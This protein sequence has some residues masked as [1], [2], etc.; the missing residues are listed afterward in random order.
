SYNHGS[1][2]AST[3]YYYKAWS[4]DG[5]I[6]YSSGV[7]ANATTLK[8]EPT[9]HVTSFTVAKDGTYGYNRIDLSWT[10]NDGAQAPDGYLIKAS[11]A[12][13][14]TDPSDG[15]A[16]DDNTT[17]GSNSGAINIAHGTTSY[18]W[19]GL[20]AEQ[21]YYFKIY[22]YTNSGTAI[23]YKTDGTV[24]SGSTTTN[25][26]PSFPNAWINEIHYDNVDAD[27]N[28]GVEVV[29][30]N[31]GNYTLSNFSVQFY[32]GSGGV[33]YAADTLGTF[34][35]GT[36]SNNFTIFYKMVPGLQNGPPD[37][38]ALCYGAHVITSQFLSYEGTITATEGP[39]LGL[40]S[41]DIGVSEGSGTTTQSLQ[42]T[43][44]GTAYSDF[45][46]QAN[47]TQTWGTKNDGGD[48]SLPVELIKFEA[49]SNNGKVILAWTTES[50]TDNLGF[51]LESRAECIE[52]GEWT[53]VADYKSAVA[54]A[55]QGSTTQRTDYQYTD[56]AV[57]P[58][59]T[60]FY[61]L[62]DVDYAGNLTWH[63]T[64]QVTVPAAEQATQAT[65]FGLHR[66]YPNPFNPAVTLSYDITSDNQTTLQ[67]FNV[68]G[69]LV[70]TLVDEY[71]P[72][73]SYSLSWQPNLLSAGV[74]LV[75]L[76]NGGQ[77]NVQKV[78]YVK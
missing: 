65:E 13:N 31:I 70:A 14:I 25:A 66:A 34:T 71:Q 27:E 9:N 53:T 1:L 67:V 22:P 15:T 37:G 10:A 54:L 61:R 42:L 51:L 63:Q 16:V 6:S 48:Q 24:P 50:E 58:G 4:V 33:I 39:A 26:A 19:T 47:L 56:C 49:I 59:V 23:D 52:Q 40:T 5:S 20:T 7:T 77:V 38:L 3:A 29:I 72:A 76:Q 45:T 30:E 12:D 68:R 43:G 62:G 28:E 69:Q 46:W 78:V 60:Y 2:S 75:Q 8:V 74:Y 17:I 44:S 57:L 73:N 32:N 18:E 55:G 21:T 36:T 64:V 11:T 41:T 35:E